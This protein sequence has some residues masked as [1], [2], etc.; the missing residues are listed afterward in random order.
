MKKTDQ[1]CP[2]KI[3][4]KWISPEWLEAHRNDA[5]LIIIDCRQNSHSYFTDHIPKAIHLHES[6]LRLHVGRIP[7]RW[8]PAELAHV[9]FRILGL[10]QDNPVVVYS[11]CRSKNSSASVASDGLEASFVAYS[12]V[13][14]GC[15]RVMIL[16]GGF[17]QWRNEGRPRAQDF[18]ETLPSGFTV[19]MPIDLFIAYEECVRI[20]DHPNVVL[21]DT[22]PTGVYEGSGPWRKPGHIPG[23]VNL[24]ATHLM[25]ANNTTRLKP[26]GEIRSILL[27]R[28]I[29]PEKT[30]ICSCGTGRTATSV[31]LILKWYIGYT[32]VVRFEGGF[33]EWV[34]H[35]ENITVT[36]KMPR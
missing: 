4:I 14:F 22:R 21:L 34:S 9:L 2:D 7:V 36:G 32:N 25:D 1:K 5:G 26:E 16:D 23:A 19:K 10:E 20:K 8:I 31:F 27:D 24:P 35:A 3:M 15:R 11:E 12:L 30:I 33:T 17:E 28:G 18:G 29:T 6:L 13:R